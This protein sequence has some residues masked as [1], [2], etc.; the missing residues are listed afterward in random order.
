VPGAP[1]QGSEEEAENAGATQRLALGPW[2]CN[3]VQHISVR[4]STVNYSTVQCS[5]FCCCFLGGAAG[6]AHPGPVSAEAAA[7]C[8]SR[9]THPWR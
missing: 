6:P 7:E 2:I 5:R 8:A 4:F 1:L 9:L 3:T